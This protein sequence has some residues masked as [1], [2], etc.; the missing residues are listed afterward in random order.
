MADITFA[1]LL[2]KKILIGITYVDKQEN[3]LDRKQFW[4]VVEDASL[5]TGIR[6]ALKNSSDPCVLPPD[7]NAI[8]IASPGE[9]HFKDS[10][11][12]IRDPDFITT[13]TCVDRGSKI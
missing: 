8:R 11:E 3:V 10:N 6:V 1:E 5:E 4:G 2:G 12:T 13:W 7:L 9:Y